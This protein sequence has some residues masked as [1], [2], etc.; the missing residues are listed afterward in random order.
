[1]AVRTT[2]LRQAMKNRRIGKVSI[3]EQIA[4]CLSPGEVICWLP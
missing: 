3:L 2:F 1:M 4:D